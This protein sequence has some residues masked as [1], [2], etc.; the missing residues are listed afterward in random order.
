M[1]LMRRFGVG[2]A[3][4]CNDGGRSICCGKEEREED[5]ETH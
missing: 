2:F 4:A 5:N 3:T 1:G